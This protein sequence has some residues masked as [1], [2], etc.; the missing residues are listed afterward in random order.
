M[1]GTRD[2]YGRRWP[3]QDLVAAT[4]APLQTL[5]ERAGFTKR[6]GHRW[7][8]QGWID[9]VI[10]D[11]LA[12]AAGWPPALVWRTW[13]AGTVDEDLFD[14]DDPG[15]AQALLAPAERVDGLVLVEQ[16]AGAA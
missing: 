8:L 13:T 5:A 7:A 15:A 4:G 16:L 9:D 2:R 12:C 14:G 6:S 3:V 11:E 1:C 10:A